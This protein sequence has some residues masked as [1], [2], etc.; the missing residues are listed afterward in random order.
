MAL[1]EI[2]LKDFVRDG[3]LFCGGGS[4]SIERVQGYSVNATDLQCLT[5]EHASP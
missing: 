4:D 3:F 5:H 1:C 2:R